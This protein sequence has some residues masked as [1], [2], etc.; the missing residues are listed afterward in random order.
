VTAPNVGAPDTAAGVAGQA[1]GESTESA[2]IVAQV[3]AERK[4][5]TTLAAHAAMAGYALHQLVDGTLMV[6]RWQWCR[7]L[8]DLDAAARWLRSA[9][10]RV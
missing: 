9:G 7:A 4:R 6:S 3:D 10:V 2:A 1:P 5:F 8:P